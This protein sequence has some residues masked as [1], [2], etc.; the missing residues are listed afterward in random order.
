MTLSLKLGMKISDKLNQNKMLSLFQVKNRESNYEALRLL[1]ML[2]IL[3]LHSFWG[4][5]YGEGVIQAVDFFREST[6]ICAVNVFILISGYFGIRWNKKSLYSL[7]FQVLFYSFGVYGVSLCLGIISYDTKG[8]L[9]CFMALFNSWGFITCYLMLYFFAPILNSYADQSE[10]KTL[11][12]FIIILFVAENFIF[13]SVRFVN[14]CLVYLIGRF[15]KK[16]EAVDNLKCNATILYFGVT[17]LIF[18]I[19]YPLFL[20][21]HFDAE[22]MCKLVVAYSYASPLVILQAVFLFLI[23]GKL[24]I[25]SKFI[26]WC[27]SSCL[28]IFLIHMH[29]A[30][31]N[32]GYYGFTRKLYETTFAEHVAILIVLFISVFFFSI[33]IDKLRIIISEL[34]YMMLS[35]VYRFI[36]NKY[37]NLD[38][39]LPNSLKN[40]L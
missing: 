3:N 18:M 12:T 24:K 33:L 7:I 36:P 39:Y 29:P 8:F 10:K 37:F 21:T 6:S 11:L 27:S 35:R 23:F 5:D 40:L 38:F 31:K 17:A 16:T 30:I 9:Q 22:M 2:M 1:S 32:I 13:V 4:Y 15:I 14:F 28:A 26:N 20:I 25:K 34:V 19:V